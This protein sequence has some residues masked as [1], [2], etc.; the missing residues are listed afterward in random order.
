MS[1]CQS[2]KEW[3]QHTVWYTIPDNPVL[4]LPVYDKFSTLI[5]SLSLW[6]YMNP[7]LQLIFS[8]KVIISFEKYYFYFYLIQ[9]W[10]KMLCIL[11]WINLKSRVGRCSCSMEFYCQ[12][13]VPSEYFWDSVI[14]NIFP[15][16]STYLQKNFICMLSICG[17]N[18][19]CRAGCVTEWCRRLQSAD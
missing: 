18:R 1:F 12:R 11:S 10:N 13:E 17:S 9:L 14:H 5:L 6:I 4:L 15:L 16:Q 19:E 7:L 3:L 2:S 8:G